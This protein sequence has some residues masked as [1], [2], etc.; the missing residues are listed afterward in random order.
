[1][2]AHAGALGA[3]WRMLTRQ[4]FAS[5]A[6]LLALASAVALPLA[7]ITVISAVQAI[8]GGFDAEPQLTVVLAA[9]VG[10]RERD[11][12][13]RD[14]RAR[15]GVRTARLV[16]KEQALAELETTEGVKDVLAGL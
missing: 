12:L 15:P 4:P 5:A 16:K 3:A 14:L 1:M 8:A 6:S 10:T 13:L 11:G 2:R 7:A 9:G